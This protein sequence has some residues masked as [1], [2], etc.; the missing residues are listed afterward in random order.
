M[1]KVEE[2]I[3]ASK[4]GEIIGMNK[5]KKEE[6]AKKDDCSKTIICIF[7]IIGAVLVVAGI[8]YGVYRYMTAKA[9]E[10]FE[11]EFEDDFDEDFEETEADIEE[12]FEAE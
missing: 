4:L 10:D 8:A 7:A 2:I 3:A 6:L 1:T 9:L 12:E 11:E 5:K